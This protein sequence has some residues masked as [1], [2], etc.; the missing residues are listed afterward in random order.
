MLIDIHAFTGHWPFRRLRGNTLK[1]LLDRMNK[2]GVNMAVVSSINGIFYKNTQSAN[3]ELH[4]EIKSNSKFSKR[5]IPFA[6]INPSYTDWEYDLDIS[7]KKLGMK[8]I[9]L[10]PQY[11]DYEITDSSCIK[12]VKNARDRG[13]PVS[14]ALRVVDTRQRSWLDTKKVFSIK[15]IADVISEV[16]DAKYIILHFVSSNVNDEVV[17]TIKNANII[18]D[19]VRLVSAPAGWKGCYIPGIIEKYGRDKVAF[20]TATPFLDYVTSFI[21]IE[22]LKEADEATKELIWSGNAKRIL[23]L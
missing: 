21:R 20:G 10:Y 5:F 12:L 9:R 22:T 17:R 1:A 13:I 16:P 2:Y 19:T 23:G 18:F 3:E 11:H 4:E 14:F 15:D 7:C 8:G 6:V